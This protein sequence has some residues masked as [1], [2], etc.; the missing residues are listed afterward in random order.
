MN[1]L[2]KV[3][4][5]G[6]SSGIGYS[7]TQLFCNKGYNT[8]NISRT[9]CQVNGVTNILLDLSKKNID[10]SVIRDV[11]IVIDCVGINLPSAFEEIEDNDLDRMFE[12]N[13][14]SKFRVL[15]Q[16][17]KYNKLSRVVIVSS[18]WGVSTRKGRSVYSATKHALTG[19][20]KTLALEYANKEVLINLVSPG[21]TLTE[22]TAQTNTDHELEEIK[23]KI[24]LKRLAEPIEI[25]RLIKFLTSDDNTYISGQ[26]IIIDGGFTI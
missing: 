3:L 16:L 13:V 20:V 24:P 21:F 19:L 2:P 17:F 7:V 11:G 9:P 14:T 22:L 15:R 1:T 23:A 25:A 6:G 18:I 5:L 4:V 10:L 8:I 26:N 12:V